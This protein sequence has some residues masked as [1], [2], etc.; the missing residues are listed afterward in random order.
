MSEVFCNISQQ[1]IQS[2]VT[3]AQG[4]VL[5]SLLFP[6]YVNYIYRNT[7]STTRLF[8]DDCIIYRKIINNNMENLL[9]DLNRLENG[10]LKM[11]R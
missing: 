3:S 6:I 10:L 1:A 2:N 4:S 7:E 9:I 8:A 11:R 5:G